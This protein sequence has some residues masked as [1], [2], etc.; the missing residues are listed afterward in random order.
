MWRYFFS[1]GLVCLF[2]SSLA[3]VKKHFKIES[4]NRYKTVTLNYNSSSGACYV[5]PG[6]SDE[7]IAVYS[8]RD[9]DEF[10]HTFDKSTYNN[11]LEINLS[12]EAKNKETFS[13]SISSRVFRNEKPE[14]NTWKVFL[15][16]D[17]PYNLNLTYGVG[18][19]YIDLSSIKVNSFHVRTGSADVNIGYLTDMPNP[20][21]MD[22]FNVKVDLGNVTVRKL[23]MAKAQNIKTEVGFGSMM[24]D[25]SE[26]PTVPSHVR[27]SVGAGSMEILIPKSDCSII[28]RV[29]DSM[30]CDVHLTKSFREISDNVYVNDAYDEDSDNQL[31]FDVDVS[32]GSITFK[33]KR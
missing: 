8:D 33:E 19:A 23:Y 18:E 24:L 11:S 21:V 22:T 14:D 31:S 25:L 29:K 3:Q 2:G 28:V 9:I 20:V 5:G 30:L 32:L 6:E 26:P 16:E 1:L 4:N 15:T 10:N 17:I 27:A 13:Q 12:I 7:P